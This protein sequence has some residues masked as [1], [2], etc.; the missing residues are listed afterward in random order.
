VYLEKKLLRSIGGLLFITAATVAGA[1]FSTTDVRTTCPTPT[2][3]G[4]YSSAS[5]ACETGTMNSWLVFSNFVNSQAAGGL[6]IQS[7]ANGANE[8]FY[9]PENL[10][11]P[12]NFQIGFNVQ[13]INEIVD[14]IMFHVTA[15]APYQG[16]AS[17]TMYVCPG[18]AVGCDTSTAKVLTLGSG[19][20]LPYD[21]IS[22]DSTQSLGVLFVGNV[23]A[24][25]MLTQFE[26]T[27]IA[28]TPEPAALYMVG[29][30]FLALG[31][32]ARMRKA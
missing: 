8:G 29:I 13:A 26:S 11:G 16:Q 14:G 6:T 24:N 9:F 4:V 25:A 30:G 17:V 10:S 1:P 5:T 28:S 22:F 31:A 15:S 3:V 7:L 27:V 20:S 32:A 19:S 23:D 18:Q 2:T 12:S 21:T